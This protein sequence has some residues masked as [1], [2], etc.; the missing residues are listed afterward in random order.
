MRAA[1][2]LAVKLARE[3]SRRLLAEIGP[4]NMAQLIAENAAC[5][6][7]GICY[8]HDYCDAN[9]VMIDSLPAIGQSYDGSDDEQWGLIDDAW[10]IARAS[11]FATG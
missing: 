2:T 10:D 4:E 9:Q 8:S 11:Q 1:D 7:E 6:V 3:F 5:A